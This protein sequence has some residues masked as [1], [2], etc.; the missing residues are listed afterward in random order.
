MGVESDPGT[1]PTTS[2]DKKQ[3]LPFLCPPSDEEARQYYFGLPSFP[4]LV[5]R[6]SAGIERWETFKEQYTRQKH[7]SHKRPAEKVLSAVGAHKILVCWK[8]VRPDILTAIDRLP[9][10]SVDVCRIGFSAAAPSER[11]IVVW[12]GING[13]STKSCD[14]PWEDV[15]EAFRSCRQILDHA[16]LDDVDCQLRISRVISLAGP[17]LLKPLPMVY[18]PWHYIGQRFTASIGLSFS[19]L[20][21]PTLEGS[22]GVFLTT[23]SKTAGDGPLLAVTCRH[24]G[25]P[26]KDNPDNAYFRFQDDGKK[27]AVGLSVQSKAKEWIKELSDLKNTTAGSAVG[28]EVT[29]FYEAVKVFGSDDARKIGHVILSPPIGL[30]QTA[31]TWTRDWCL[32]ELDQSK[33][34]GGEKPVNVVDLR[35]Y[36][37]PSAV[38]ELL[39]S[40]VRDE[41]R[42]E[43]PDNGLLRLPGVIPLA[44]IRNPTMCDKDGENC[45]IVGKRGAISGL[46]WGAALDLESTVR[47]CMPDGSIFT[48]YEWAIHGSLPKKTVPFSGAGDS[49]AAVFDLQGRL[50]GFVTRGTKTDLGLDVDIT[51]ATPAEL[52]LADIEK[53]HGQKVV[54]L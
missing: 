6:A 22:L 44:E 31:A 49:G 40:H 10:S 37:A 11:P 48:S 46:T 16:G 53:E 35:T 47:D 13:D 7:V 32:L 14:L 33:F 9:W 24:V 2:P 5:G 30:Q 12:V 42:F 52:G 29:E 15:A 19:P 36:M 21:R 8:D 20:E 41:K 45:I 23:E 50:G 34:L 43:F 39:N 3:I 25:I 54:L 4:R 26:S 51:Y 28:A 18:G 27:R 1:V 38:N 17:R